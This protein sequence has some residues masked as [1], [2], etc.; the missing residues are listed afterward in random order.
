MIP[1][2]G[3]VRVIAGGLDGVRGPARTFTAVHL[4][5][6]RLAA[7]DRVS[8]S[9]PAGH[10]S[11]LVLLKGRV[12]AGGTEVAGGPRL[13]LLSQAGNAIDLAASE[14]SALLILGG[15]PI[16]EPVASYGPFVM[17]THDEIRQAIEDYRAGRM[18]RLSP[19]R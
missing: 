16:L 10:N 15:E 19:P 3:S 9:I 5:D 12:Q 18:G 11:A 13:A 7:G 4:F 6:V 1:S 17:N 8:V 14:D 2:A